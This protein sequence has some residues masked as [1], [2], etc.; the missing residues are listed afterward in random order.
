MGER[1]VTSASICAMSIRSPE[2]IS[3]TI[4]RTASRA[5][6]S[7]PPGTSVAFMLALP[8][9]STTIERPVAEAPLTRGSPK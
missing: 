6:R 4:L 8:S 1:A 9:T 2:P 7:R 5:A 3:R